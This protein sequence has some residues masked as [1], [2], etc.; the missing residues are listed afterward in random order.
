MDCFV[1]RFQPDKYKDWVEGNEKLV[2]PE[3]ES[4]NQMLPLPTTT[5]N[6]PSLS[7]LKEQIMG[8]QTTQKLQKAQESPT[9]QSLIEQIPTIKSNTFCA[10]SPPA[11][12]TQDSEIPSTLQ[13]QPPPCK[14]T[15]KLPPAYP[16][17]TC[18]TSILMHQASSAQAKHQQQILPTPS[19][20]H[21]QQSTAALK[22][23]SQEMSVASSG[24]IGEPICTGSGTTGEISGDMNYCS[25]SQEESNFLSQQLNKT[26]S[27]MTPEAH[28]PLGQC[29][30]KESSQRST[31][32]NQQPIKTKAKR[33]SS[34]VN[35]IYYI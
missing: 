27:E 23:E 13:E 30:S 7:P 4:E 35:T 5:T 24:F 1:E 21:P 11:S 26:Q 12:P 6:S 19:V 34:K 29:S 9:V 32:E 2:H 8:K 22:E 20:P 15:T 14:A 25:G 31:I 28:H 16:S 18:P 33:Q 17:R 3:T 10:Q